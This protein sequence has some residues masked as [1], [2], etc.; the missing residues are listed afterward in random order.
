MSE[1]VRRKKG[2]LVR[3]FQHEIGEH[4]VSRRQFGIEL[5]YPVKRPSIHLHLPVTNITLFFNY[6]NI[7][8]M[9]RLGPASVCQVPPRS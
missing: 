6:C 4:F 9:T 5:A 1:L 2:D 8:N 3:V 7:C